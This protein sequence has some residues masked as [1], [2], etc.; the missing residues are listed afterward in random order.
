MSFVYWSGL[1]FTTVERPQKWFVNSLGGRGLRWKPKLIQN[2]HFLCPLSVESL[3]MIQKCSNFDDFFWKH[4]NYLLS[5]STLSNFL[6]FSYKKY[7]LEIPIRIWIFKTIILWF[8]WIKCHN[9][10]GETMFRPNENLS[11]Q[12]VFSKSVW[13]LSTFQKSVKKWS[14]SC[15][16]DLNLRKAWPIWWLW[17]NSWLIKKW[18]KVVQSVSIRSFSPVGFHLA[19]LFYEG[20][21]F[22]SP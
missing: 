8:F 12:W 20:D 1:H 7:I 4:G 5:N 17:R 9:L 15:F 14:K 11:L 19:E 2:H 21:I 13:F 6:G 16:S 22:N 18:S 10:S 3:K